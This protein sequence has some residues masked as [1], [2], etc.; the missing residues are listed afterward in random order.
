MKA[1]LPRCLLV[2]FMAGVT[3]PVTAQ[4]A[5][6]FELDDHPVTLLVVIVVGDDVDGQ[7]SQ[8]AQE[9]IDLGKSSQRDRSRVSK[10][11]A[12]D[13]GAKARHA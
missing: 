11:K 8:D 3:L 6:F 13:C 1:M 10:N 4:D 7:Q 2:P 9:D 5:E 12:G